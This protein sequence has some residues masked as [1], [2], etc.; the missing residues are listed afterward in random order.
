MANNNVKKG[1]N[2]NTEQTLTNTDAFF[3]KYKKAVIAG[4][5]AIVIIVAGIVIYR[6][7]VSI[8]KEQK[9]STLLG[10]GQ[11][12]FDNELY[13]LALNGDSI[14]YGGFL[15]VAEDYSGTDA[16][17]LANLYAGLC[18]AQL[19]KW[20]QAAS[21]IE[22][23]KSRDDAMISPAAEGALGNVYA[24]MGQLDK[25][26]DHLKKAAKEADNYSLSPTFLIQ[27][28][29]ILESQGKND[30]ALSLYKEVKA[31]Y[32]SSLQY[33]SIDKYIERVSK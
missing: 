19:G 11:Q 32:F 28:G 33:Q 14:S 10:K 2:N 23:F 6:N 4:V 1:E 7:Y 13:D 20:E 15:Q 25:A 27:A 12:L 31:K 5:V 26:V 18:Y 29:E 21:Y 22:K 16:G 9:A 3:V 17:N 24:H 8:P 30:E